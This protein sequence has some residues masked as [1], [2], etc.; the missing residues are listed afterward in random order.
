MPKYFRLRKAVCYLCERTI[1][2]KKQ[3]IRLLSTSICYACKKLIDNKLETEMRE[4]EIAANIKSTW[5][6]NGVLVIAITGSEFQAPGIPDC[7]IATPD[8]KYVGWVEWKNS[9]TPIKMHQTIMIGKIKKFCPVFV[10]RFDSSELWS[11]RDEN[12]EVIC[13]L[14][15]SHLTF[16]K[17]CA[18]L[19]EML[20]RLVELDSEEKN[21]S[22]CNTEE[23]L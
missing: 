14:E 13:L 20:E 9:K 17:K 22:R 5:R 8:R 1:L 18:A 6:K 15:L 19:L 2:D 3:A 4:G 16:P 23:V 12:N 7:W 21:G 11:I 10:I